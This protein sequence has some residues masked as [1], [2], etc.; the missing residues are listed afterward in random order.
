MA[1]AMIIRKSAVLGSEP[2]M[3]GMGPI[4]I[5]LPPLVFAL[6]S[7]SLSSSCSC[8]PGPA[9]GQQ[10]FFLLG[11]KSKKRPMMMSAI[12]TSSMTLNLASA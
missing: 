12:P 2:Q 6:G 5:T 3:M 7:G 1:R 8:R 9:A 10:V 4:I 11:R